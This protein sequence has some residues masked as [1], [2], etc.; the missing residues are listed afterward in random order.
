MPYLSLHSEVVRVSAV[1][2][3]ASQLPKLWRNDRESTGKQKTFKRNFRVFLY[4]AQNAINAIWRL[5]LRH[6]VTEPLELK[7][8]CKNIAFVL[9]NK[10]K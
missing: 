10:Y 7:F 6:V 4:Y 3:V 1:L 5:T 9:N 8:L 2:G